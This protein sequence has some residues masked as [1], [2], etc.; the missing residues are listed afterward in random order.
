MHTSPTQLMPIV[1]S[2]VLAAIVAIALAQTPAGQR[3]T[4]VEER[5]DGHEDDD[6]KDQKPV[7]LCPKQRK[8]SRIL[9]V[10]VLFCASSTIWMYVIYLRCR[11]SHME[12]L[13]L[14]VG[15]DLKLPG[16]V[17]IGKA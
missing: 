16:G 17:Q 8:T 9:I 2:S 15:F 12:L 5:D 4:S 13:E 3:K 14:T 6:N 11:K 10:L 1:T 7:H